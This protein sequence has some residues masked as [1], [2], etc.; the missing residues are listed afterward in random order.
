MDQSGIRPQQ[1]I[2]FD[3]V[4]Q[5]LPEFKPQFG[6]KKA[7]YDQEATCVKDV[8]QWDDG[9]HESFRKMK[10]RELQRSPSKWQSEQRDNFRYF[11]D[12]HTADELSKPKGTKLAYDGE[13]PNRKAAS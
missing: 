8:F 7:K 3:L 6:R 2:Q 12:Q 1:V 4:K 11:V 10:L 13:S 9:Y 5:D